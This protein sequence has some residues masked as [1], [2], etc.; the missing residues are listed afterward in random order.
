MHTRKWT[1]KVGVLFLIGSVSL[2]AT[3]AISI[4]IVQVTSNSMSSFIEAGDIVAIYKNKW[5]T[6]L[7]FSKNFK[8][9]AFYSNFSGE[10]N[11]YIKRICAS[12]SDTI[13]IESDGLRINSKRYPHDPVFYMLQEI[14]PINNFTYID[15]LVRTSINAQSEKELVFYSD[16]YLIV[17][18]GY[19]FVIGDN[20]YESM[21]SRF[22]G[23]IHE[24]QV[25]GKVIGVF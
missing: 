2:I 1:K 9:I 10:E 22:W 18:K 4:K 13:F 7:R 14:E 19:Y 23:F 11:I 8:P 6:P 20:Y 16:Q 24:S 3:I 15:H 12:E 25:I 17:P 5:V 21:D